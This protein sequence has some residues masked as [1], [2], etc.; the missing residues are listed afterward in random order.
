[1]KLIKVIGT[2]EMSNDVFQLFKI[3]GCFEKDGYAPYTVGY[4][5]SESIKH[6]AEAL[7]KNDFELVRGYDQQMKDEQLMDDYALGQG[8]NHGEKILIGHGVY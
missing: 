3:A 1:M 8:A 7:A 4:F 6:R 5:I 2:S